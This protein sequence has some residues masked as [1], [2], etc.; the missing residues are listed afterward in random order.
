M[1][2]DSRSSQ[3]FLMHCLFLYSKPKRKGKLNDKGEKYIFFV[4][5]Y[6]SISYK[7]CNRN[8]KIFVISRDVIFY[9]ATFWTSSNDGA[10]QNKQN[11][12][13]YLNG[14]NSKKKPPIKKT[15]QP[16]NDQSITNSQIS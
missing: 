5:S 14:Y 6:Y 12:S 9:E 2:T 11:I 3:S 8:T 13:M 15:P 16:M 7:L 4:I 10:K 1:K